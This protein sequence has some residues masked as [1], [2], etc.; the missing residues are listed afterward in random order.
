MP[1]YNGSFCVRHIKLWGWAI[2]TNKLYFFRHTFPSLTALDSRLW[3]EG[4]WGVQSCTF[5]G[6]RE[7]SLLG[8]QE[9]VRALKYFFVNEPFS[10]ISLK[11]S[12]PHNNMYRRFIDAMLVQRELKAGKSEF[13]KRVAPEDAA[14]LVRDRL[15]LLKNCIISGKDTPSEPFLY[16]LH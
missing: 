7:P 6:H 2:I 5:Q 1:F 13:A 14:R 10:S 16:H 12:P 8:L 4:I 15:F 3:F 11:F 9:K